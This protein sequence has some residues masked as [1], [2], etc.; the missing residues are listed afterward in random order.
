MRPT[1]L[2]IDDDEMILRL[3][4]EALHQE[5]Y[6]VICTADGPQGISIYTE[7]HPNIVLLDFGLPSMSG[8]EVLRKIREIDP[9]ARV[10]VIT[11]HASDESAEVALLHGALDYLR[12]PVRVQ[13]ILQLLKSHLTI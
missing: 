6:D 2:L 8:L 5:G 9:Q 3:M 1:V 13:S 11:G 10:V 12:K 7:R 4:P